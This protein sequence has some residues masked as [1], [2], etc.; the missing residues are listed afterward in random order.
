MLFGLDIMYA[1]KLIA[2][3]AIICV[4][5]LL[6]THFAAVNKKNNTQTMYVRMSS[7][8]LFWTGIG[9]F[10]GLYKSVAK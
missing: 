5:L 9:W 1:I 3:I 10:F 4:I 8:F 7:I 6:P 2:Y